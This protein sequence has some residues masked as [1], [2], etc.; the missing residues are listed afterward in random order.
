MLPA[1]KA[2]QANIASA[3][4]PSVAEKKNFRMVNSPFLSNCR[5]F[6]EVFTEVVLSLPDHY[7]WLQDEILTK[8]SSHFAVSQVF[9]S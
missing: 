8:R 5:T 1:A 6:F 2:C 9:R 4:A 7:V 3:A